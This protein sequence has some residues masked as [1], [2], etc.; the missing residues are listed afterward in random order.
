MKLNLNIFKRNE[1]S[2]VTTIEQSIGKVLKSEST[3]ENSVTSPL[4]YHNYDPID[5]LQLPA[6]YAALSI[7]SNSIATLPIYVKQYKD[8]ERTILQNHK[9]Q[10]LFYNM[11]QSKHTVIKQ[12]VWDL[13]LYGNSFIYIKRVGG[14]PDRLIY[15][16]H[17]D[18]QIN[19][20]K[21]D[22][23]V[24]YQCCNH[25]AVPSLVKSDDMLHFARD[26]RD[27]VN[28][29]GFFYFA[30]EVIKL[31]GY[32][33]QAAEDFFRSGCSLTGILKFKQGLR[34]I[35]Q[36]DI[37][38]QWM[39]IHSHGARGAGLGV[40]GGD[41]DYIPISQN[42][43]DSQMLETREFNL[44]DIARFFNISP[45]LLGDLSHNSYSS[46]EDSNIEFINHTLLPIINL[47]EEEINRKLI[48]VST[49]YIDFDE[50]SLLKGNRASI[51][52][53]LT[54][55]VTNGIMTTNE[56]R[57][58]IGL[59]PIDGGDSIIIPYTKIEDNTIGN[60]GEETVEENEQEQ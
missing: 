24:E 3:P 11:L 9:I 38:N 53:Y 42:S 31:A 21:E 35:Q 48:T 34:G 45:I 37:R 52:N 12:L 44:T 18:V 39:Q 20:I 5:A 1:P 27:G 47:M 58:Q 16:Q 19:Y 14:K 23:K 28:G 30:A 49:Q 33:Q 22:D 59:N 32:T 17:G 10:Q 6:V 40:L 29:R 25:K 43:A 15:L 46:I 60:N 13:L 4:L 2:T 36:Q 51:S 50:N 55:L 26:T 57:Q 41:A 7:I 54:S 56:A 8:N